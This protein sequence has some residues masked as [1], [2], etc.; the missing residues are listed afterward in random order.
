[1][2]VGACDVA[3]KRTF[4]VSAVTAHNDLEHVSNPKM[5]ELSSMSKSIDH[6]VL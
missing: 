5:R 1:M 4:S 3:R 6:P 2:P